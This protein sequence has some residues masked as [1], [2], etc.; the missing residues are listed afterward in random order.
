MSR[1]ERVKFIVSCLFLCLIATKS[2]AWG[3]PKSGQLVNLIDGLEMLDGSPVM[4]EKCKDK[5]LKVLYVNLDNNKHRA[6]KVLEEKQLG[7]D[8]AMRKMES[9]PPDQKGCPWLSMGILGDFGKI[10]TVPAAV[11]V[12][13]EGIV[14]FKYEKPDQFRN[15]ESD[16]EPIVNKR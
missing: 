13:S 6:S 1:S 12:D 3:E 8:I 4:L 11:I 9:C 2:H 14:K 16:I 5:D 7:V 15:L 10:Y